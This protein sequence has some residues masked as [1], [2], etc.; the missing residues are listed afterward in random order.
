MVVRERGALLFHLAQAV[1]P[2]CLLPPFL[3][4]KWRFRALR[5][6]IS[7]SYSRFGRDG[8][9]AGHG[10]TALLLWEIVGLDLDTFSTDTI[11]PIGF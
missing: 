8:G 1:Q 6:L 7:Y 9:N 4:G 2:T 5:L 11:A 3:G 10:Y